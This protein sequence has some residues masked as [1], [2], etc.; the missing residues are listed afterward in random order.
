MNIFLD[1]NVI[2]ENLLTREDFSSAHRLFQVI[3]KQEHSLYMSVGSF[4]TMIFLVDKFLRKER[5]LIGQERIDL[6][7]EMM[8]IILRTVNVAE[9]DNISLLR[10]INNIHF[11][12]VEDGCQYQVALKAG[13]EVLIT[14]N[15]S[16]YPVRDDS[17]IRVFTPQQY[18]DL[19]TYK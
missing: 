17:P 14:F 1:T 6:L 7:R 19:D 16:D 4:Y 12:D 3:Q 18:L 2:L 15:V 10:G 8:S 9:H 5:G 11:K 13:C